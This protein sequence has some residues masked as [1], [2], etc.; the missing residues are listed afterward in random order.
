LT[1]AIFEEATFTP[2]HMVYL[3]G[4]R[5]SPN[6][7]KA[8]FIAKWLKAHRP[9][10]V[11]F[12]PQ[13]PASPHAAADMLLNTVHSWPKHSTAI[14][15][16]SL[17]GFY[18]TWLGAL[19]QSRTVLLNPAVHPARDLVSYIGTQTAW[20]NPHEL[21]SF[22]PHYIDELKTLYVG[23]AKKDLQDSADLQD[24]TAL[25]DPSHILNMVAKG[26][27]VL[28]WQEMVARYPSATLHLIEGSDHGLSDFEQHFPVV[29]NY[30]GLL[31][32]EQQ[33]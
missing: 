22:E 4:F 1:Q 13:L 14:M 10:I 11:W 30:L 9:D 31:S 28:S 23:Q 29:T 2:S 26:D 15:G 8:Q 33:T 20:H 5:S 7:F 3:H 27:E 17:G 21:V 19:M 25:D 32:S 18:A 6:S 16:S 12:C 24:A